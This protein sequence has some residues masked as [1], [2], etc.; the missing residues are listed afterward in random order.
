MH[1]EGAVEE[2]ICVLS[3]QHHQELAILQ[4]LSLLFNARQVN[5]SGLQK[6]G[7]FHTLAHFLLAAAVGTQGQQ[8]LSLP[9]SV[10]PNGPR[11]HIQTQSPSS[12]EK[13]AAPLL[14]LDTLLRAITTADILSILQTLLAER[15][16]LLI[17]RKIEL[18]APAAQALLSLLAPWEWPY[19]YIPLLPESIISM[20]ESPVP[21]LLGAL[22]DSID[23]STFKNMS[24]DTSIVNLDTGV[25]HQPQ[26]EVSPWASAPNTTALISETIARYLVGLKTAEQLQTIYVEIGEGS[27]VSAVEGDWQWFDL[28]RKALASLLREVQ[29]ESERSPMGSSGDIDSF[30]LDVSA[31]FSVKNAQPQRADKSKKWLNPSFGDNIRAAFRFPTFT[32]QFPSLALCVRD[33]EPATS[34][35]HPIRNHEIYRRNYGVMNLNS[36]G[37]AVAPGKL[38]GEDTYNQGE[39]ASRDGEFANSCTCVEDAGLRRSLEESVSSGLVMWSNNVAA[40]EEASLMGQRSSHLAALALQHAVEQHLVRPFLEQH[41]EICGNPCAS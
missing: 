25:V 1:S 22:S 20:V 2:V 14:A 38:L 29:R 35:H 23:E 27:T 36:E 18:L 24:K 28:Q 40:V 37:S 4:C 33:N 16:V 19:I 32:P 26:P 9:I 13:P 11:V 8:H 31:S 30:L 10:V 17:S 39:D 41:P 6:G 34:I 15:K 5:C 21:F 12:R 7:H 3:T